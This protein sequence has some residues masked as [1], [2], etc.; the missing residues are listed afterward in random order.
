MPVNLEIKVRLKSHKNVKTILNSIG[1]E[2]M[3]I[4]KQKDIYYKGKSQLLK[5]RIQGNKN[6]FIR[7]NRDESGK[8]RWSNYDIIDM[9]GKKIPEFLQ[10]I[11][12]VETIV[13]KRRELWYFDDTRIHLDTVK[14]LGQ[15]LELETLVLKKGRKDAEKR[16]NYMVNTLDLDVK[17]QIRSSY[18]TLMLKI[19]K[20]K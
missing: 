18:R 5:L 3:G 20:K 13:E 10:S 11:L 2:F 9:Q 12:T 7:Y 15:F 17:G 1:A 6:E 16:F 8:T 19:S 14:G 4:L